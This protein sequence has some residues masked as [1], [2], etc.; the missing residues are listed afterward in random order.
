[1]NK[2]VQAKRKRPGRK[3]RQHVIDTQ[4]L[5]RTVCGKPIGDDWEEVEESVLPCKSCIEKIER[6]PGTRWNWRGRLIPGRDM[7]K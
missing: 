6:R 4:L 3:I 5:D 1:M 7:G 2:W